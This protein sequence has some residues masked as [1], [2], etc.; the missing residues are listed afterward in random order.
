MLALVTVT[1]GE[2]KG[3]AKTEGCVV[4]VFGTVDSAVDATFPKF[5]KG[6]LV[7]ALPPKID[8]VLSGLVGVVNDDIEKIFPPEGATNFGK[9]RDTFTLAH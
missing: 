9:I 5:E 1:F 4:G 3:V 2:A 6:D 8:D 7:A